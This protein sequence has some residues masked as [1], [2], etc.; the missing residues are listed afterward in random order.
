MQVADSAIQKLQEKNEF[1]IARRNACL[2]IF[3]QTVLRYHYL[4]FYAS[5]KEDYSI[6]RS[7]RME[8]LQESMKSRATEGKSAQKCK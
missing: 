2:A 1:Y 6:W 7:D 8:S 4:D 5:C 3:V